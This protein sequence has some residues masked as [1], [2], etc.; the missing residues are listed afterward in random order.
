MFSGLAQSGLFSFWTFLFDYIS[1]SFRIMVLF[2][3]V[4]YFLSF[5]L[6]VYM[7]TFRFN[8]IDVEV[9]SVV[10]QQLLTIKTA[11]DSHAQRFVLKI[12]KRSSFNILFIQICI[13]WSWNKN[14]FNLWIFC[15]NVNRLIIIHRK[16]LFLLFLGIQL[17]LVVLNYLI[18]LNLC[19]DPLLWWSHI[20]L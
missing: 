17:I 16:Y 7:C 19:F 11:K 12:W 4:G 13:W 9:L 8:R 15:N 20:I 1:F 14:E 2:R 6:S 5:S 10:A 18:I 3:W